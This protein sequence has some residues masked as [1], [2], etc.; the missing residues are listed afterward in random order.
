MDDALPARI[1]PGDW[2]EL[3]YSLCLTDGLPT[4]PPERR[5][6]DTLVDGSGLAGSHLVGAVPPSGRSATVEAIAANAAMAG[7]RPEYMP[8]VIAALEA[9][10]EPRFNLAGVVTTTHPCW[11][12]AI[13]SGP[14]VTSSSALGSFFRPSLAVRPRTSSPNPVLC[15]KSADPKRE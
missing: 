15:Q 3:S 7:C 5:V 2:Q 13:V 14:V 10:L 6:V 8:A 1:E 11:P 9:M 4:F 12:L